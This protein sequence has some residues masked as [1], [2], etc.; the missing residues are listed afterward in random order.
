M[1]EGGKPQPFSPLIDSY[2]MSQLGGFTGAKVDIAAPAASSITGLFL[3]IGLSFL[4]C[5]QLKI[6]KRCSR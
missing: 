1:A 3:F 2:Q 4:L 5:I 6:Y